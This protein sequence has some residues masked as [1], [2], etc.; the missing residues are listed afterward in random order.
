MC[1]GATLVSSATAGAADVRLRA[2]P[3]RDLASVLPDGA[4]EWLE[5]D[6][7]G[8]FACGTVGGIRTRRYHGLLIAATTPP[9]GRTM[10]VNGVE[11]WVETPAERLALLPQRYAPGVVHPQACAEIV[12]FT[13][14]PWPRWTWR[15]PDGSR[16]EHELLVPHGAA[17]CAMLWRLRSRSGK[18]TL[19]VRP[20]I[21][22]R[23]YHALHHEN[24]GLRLEAEVN[25]ECV[26]WRPYGVHPSIE[27]RTNGDYR[28][29]P[30]WYRQFLYEQ[31]QRRGFDCVE[32]LASP[33]VISF[34]LVRGEAVLIF[35]ACEVEAVQREESSRSAV[36]VL[37]GLAAVERLRRSRF[38]TPLDRAADAY[39]VARGPR[40]TIIAGYPW[41]ADWGRDTFIAM[42]GLCIASGRLEEAE[43][44]LL[45]W[46]DAVSRGML[47]NRFPDSASSSAAGPPEFNSVDASLWYVIAVHEFLEAAQRADLAVNERWA[48]TLH[49]AVCEIVAGY[50]GGTRYGIRADD[51]GLLAAGERGQQLTWMDARVGEREITPR[52][53]KP[54][55][56]Q[57]LWINALWIA[58]G[59]DGRWKALC[60]QARAAFARRFWNDDR[61]CLYDVID[62]DH[63]AGVVDA[64]VRP[65]QIFAV[66]GL[67]LQLI[68]GGRARA[69]VDRVERDLLTP[70]GLRSLSPHEPGYVARYEGGPHERDAAYHQ[71]TVWPW[72]IGPFVEAWVRVH[73]DDDA[74]RR[75]ARQRF[76]EPLMA[77]L[78]TAG[79]GHISEI[80]DAESPHEPRGCPFQAWSLGELL[81]LQRSVLVEAGA[82]GQKDNGRKKAQK[83]QKV[84]EATRAGAHQT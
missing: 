82:G 8:G 20:L 81:R 71:G 58:G 67:P 50:A 23:D 27:A 59:F 24:P 72:L 75:R 31:E 16:L 5:T 69:I 66:G 12:S 70:V 73:R 1:D 56:V 80:A 84:Q 28:H 53:G 29:E 18:A 10:L 32:D 33:G 44:I 2:D 42:R 60:A 63:A 64:S 65:N 11:A 14:E 21:S 62:V 39:I 68:E 3:D 41:F 52:I 22:G 54:V 6:G 51:D 76:L 35:R 13:T 43:S 36:E 26:R 34:D 61:A 37:R 78:N 15:L 79:L 30:V 7:V 19:H 46:A 74:A 38:A 45:G 49:R 25:G 9:A 83:A 48:A 77:H 40:R 57:A 4:C 55:E 47:P 17:Q